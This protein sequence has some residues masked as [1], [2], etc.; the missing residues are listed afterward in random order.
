MDQ[1]Q[2]QNQV[3]GHFL[4]FGSLVF[5]E[6]AY[7]DSSLQFL[8]SRRDKVDENIFG[9]QIWAKGAKI[10]LET[11]LFCCF[12]KFGSL[13]F[14][15]IAYNDSLQQCLTSSRDKI[16]EKHFWGPNLC[17]WGQNQAQNQVICHF[18]KFSSLVF[19]EIAYNDCLQQCPT[20]SGDKIH[21]KNLG[22]KF[23]PKQAKI[24]PKTRFLVIFSSF[25]HQFSLKLH[26]MIAYINV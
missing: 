17:Q 12:L 19:L 18:L 1:N 23:G 21:K 20:S 22:N 7:N 9:A 2:A 14:L 24:E 4:K 16:H 6:I 8:T 25:V 10:R 5:L 15:E 13:I 11:K 26:K 3:F